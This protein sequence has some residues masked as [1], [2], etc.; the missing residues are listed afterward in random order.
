M[1]DVFLV[2]VAGSQNEKNTLGKLQDYFSAAIFVQAVARH[3]W[4]CTLG[5]IL[6]F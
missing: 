6:K 3:R 1:L 2:H 4:I 5:S